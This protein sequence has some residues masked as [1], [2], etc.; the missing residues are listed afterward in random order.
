[1]S[2]HRPSTTPQSS[3]LSPKGEKPQSRRSAWRQRVF[4]NTFTRK[5]RTIRLKGWSFKV[6]VSGHRRT[7]SLSGRTRDE[8]AQEAQQIH[9]TIVSQ[10]WEAALDLHRS[11]RPSG[12][13]RPTDGGIALPLKSE[14]AYWEQRLIQRGYREG[15]FLRGPEYSAR[16][17]HDGAYAYFPLGSSN[18]EEAIAKAI[19]IHNTLIASGWTA[20]FNSFEREITL[21]VSWSDNPMAIT[22]TTLF[23]FLNEPP[24]SVQG[25]VVGDR[26]LKPLVVLEPDSTTHHC[27]RYWLNRQPGFSCRGVYRTADE[28]LTAMDGGRAT[29]VLI[30]RLAP[31]TAHMAECLRLRWPGTLVIPYRLHEDSDQIFISSSG[32]SGGYIFRRRAPSALFDP[33]QPVAQARTLTAAEAGRYI[34]NYFQNFF[35]DPNHQLASA[36]M[37]VVLTNREQEILNLIGRG[38]PDK[39]I[40]HL[41]GISI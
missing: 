28:A 37:P 21:A 14:L 35:G 9:N 34:R 15:R 40:A 13:Y 16:I 6:Q 29:V 20:A 4:R 23:T 39:E 36:L 10:G 3:D 38:C 31:D 33:L 22:Y 18:A 25:P 19:N 12:T 30:N 17:E 7:F 24:G 1:M 41:L 5:G 26:F 8:A 11:Q 32:I 27:L 2:K